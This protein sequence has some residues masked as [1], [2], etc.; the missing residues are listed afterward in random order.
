MITGQQWRAAAQALRTSTMA[1]QDR[2]AAAV[3]L[4]EPVWVM[5]GGAFLRHP[6]LVIMGARALLNAHMTPP[7]GSRT[8]LL[9]DIGHALGAVY[10]GGTEAGMPSRDIDWKLV[11]KF[12]RKRSSWTQLLNEYAVLLDMH[13]ATTA[14]GDRTVP[15]Y[16]YAVRTAHAK[17]IEIARAARDRAQ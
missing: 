4:F 2:D 5:L 16:A 11:A 9:V 12:V 6:H 7:I 17:T 13:T 3:A 15:D 14:G 8:R 1:W 10:P